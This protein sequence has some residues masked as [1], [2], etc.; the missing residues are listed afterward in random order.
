MKPEPEPWS[1]GKTAADASPARVAIMV[2]AVRSIVVV[3]KRLCFGKKG[4]EW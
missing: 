1:L 2:V 4:N 3:K